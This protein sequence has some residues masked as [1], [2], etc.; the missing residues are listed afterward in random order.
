LVVTD[1]AIDDILHGLQETIAYLEAQPEPA[2]S[3]ACARLKQHQIKLNLMQMYAPRVPA[4][5]L[6]QVGKDCMGAGCRTSA[7]SMI[8]LDDHLAHGSNQA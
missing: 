4:V 5:A 2:R 3:T 1:R 7:V 6:P 8:Q